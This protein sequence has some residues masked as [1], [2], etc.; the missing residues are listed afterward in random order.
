M[1]NVV[2]TEGENNT[3]PEVILGEVDPE[4][5][6]VE[7]EPEP[8]II[9]QIE[10]GPQGIPG[11]QGPP[12]VGEGT[13]VFDEIVLTPKPSSSGDAEGTIF[14]ADFDNHVYVGVK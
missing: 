2:I 14:Y 10:Q 7:P 4:T 1:S 8:V 11:P 6:V 5:I 12:G 13:N 3:V 9:V